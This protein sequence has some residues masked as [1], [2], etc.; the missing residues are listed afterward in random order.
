MYTKENY[1]YIL[2]EDE[3]QLEEWLDLMLILQRVNKNFGIG[4]SLREPLGT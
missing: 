2:F 3:A 1:F 4:D